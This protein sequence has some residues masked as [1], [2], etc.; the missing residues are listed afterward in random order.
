MLCS[1]SLWFTLR[2]LGNEWFS[3]Q[4]SGNVCVSVVLTGMYR[5]G[6]RLKANNYDKTIYQTDRKIDTNT[7]KI[8]WIEKLSKLIETEM[9]RNLLKLRYNG[10]I[11]II[12]F[13]HFVYI[14]LASSLVF[15]LP[16]L[17]LSLPILLFNISTLSD[18]S[19]ETHFFPFILSIFSY[20]HFI[21]IIFGWNIFFFYSL[22]GNMF[23]K[24]IT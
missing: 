2:L 17:S 24:N 19:I 15:F 9:E 7:H 23:R 10:L 11:H 16:S 8:Q 4:Q 22:S 6:T 14:F 13:N 18:F 1:F 5:H 12:C 3:L 20:S 21:L